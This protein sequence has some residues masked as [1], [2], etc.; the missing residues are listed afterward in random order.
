MITVIGET[1][2]N[3]ATQMVLT[4]GRTLAKTATTYSDERRRTAPDQLQLPATHTLPPSE[5][6]SLFGSLIKSPVS[7]RWNIGVVT[8]SPYVAF[9]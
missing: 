1:N 3:P 4:I 6:K 2:R 9:A 5:M 8:G 7:R